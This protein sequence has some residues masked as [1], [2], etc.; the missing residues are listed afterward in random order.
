MQQVPGG[1][2]A[3]SEQGLYI[4]LYLDLQDRLHLRWSHPSDLQSNK[5]TH[6]KQARK[7]RSYASPKLCPASDSLPYSQGCRPTSVGTLGH[8]KTCVWV[9]GSLFVYCTF[10]LHCCIYLAGS[11]LIIKTNRQPIKNTKKDWKQGWWNLLKPLDCV[12]SGHF[13]SSYKLGFHLAGPTWHSSAAHKS[14]RPR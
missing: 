14:A 1:V 13:V 10:C 3:V 11:T 9:T 4:T 8:V 7:P 12:R 6:K 2:W 5:Q